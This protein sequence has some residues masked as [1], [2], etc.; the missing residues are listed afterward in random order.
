M[1]DGQVS[2]IEAAGPIDAELAAEIEKQAAWVSA[3]VSELRVEHDGRTVRFRVARDAVVDDERAKVARFVSAVVERHRAVPRKTVLRRERGGRAI[4]G[5]VFGELVRRGWA[6]ELGRGRVSLRGPALAVVRAIED[7]TGRIARRME[8]ADEA[9]PA[10]APAALLARC[11]AFASFPHM[12]SL[13]THLTEDYDAIE[14]FRRSNAEAGP[15]VQPQ[16]DAVAPFDACLLPALCYAVYAAREGTML[17][18]GGAVV[19]CVGRCVRFESRNLAGIERLWEFGM[20]ELVFLGDDRACANGRRRALEA[21]LDQLERWDLDGVVESA[22]D[23]FFPAA[24]GG[25]AYWQRSG[26]RK[27]EL[28]MPVAPGT[29]TGGEPRRI[30]CASFNL[31]ERVFGSAFAIAAADGAP[32]STG[33]VGWGLER[34]ML[35]C[36]AQHG[37]DP[38]RW[39]SWLADRV[40]G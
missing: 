19:T 10:L 26:D 27:L 28:Q 35:A 30:A 15:W 14:A 2:V 12:V 21:V 37:F 18:E 3:R 8:A 38:A 13:V 33:C 4:A 40:F 5:D 34:W 22:S 1:S 11:G 7:D 24:R 16:R 31:H 6:V 36:F 25:R 39:P 23:P 9:H 20:R 29:G 32:A 17:P